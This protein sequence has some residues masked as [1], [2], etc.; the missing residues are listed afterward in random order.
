MARMAG[1]GLRERYEGWRREPFTSE[2]RTH[3]SVWR[4]DD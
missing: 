1:M 3:V 2:S 4:K